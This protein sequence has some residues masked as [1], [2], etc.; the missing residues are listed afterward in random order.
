MMQS[1]PPAKKRGMIIH[2]IL[3]FVFSVAFVFSMVQLLSSDL[4]FVVSVYVLIALASGVGFALMGYRLF[5]LYNANYLLDRNFLEINWGLRFERIPVT[6]IDWIK[7]ISSFDQAIRMPLIHLPGGILGEVKDQSIGFVEYLAADTENLVLIGTAQRIFAISPEDL[8]SFMTTF[9]RI[10]ELGSLESDEG[11]SEFVNFAI[12]NAWKENDNKMLWG[13]TL[14]MNIAFLTLVIFLVP[15]YS[16]INLSVAQTNQFP[17]Q[18]PARQL[19][20]LPMINFVFSLFGI[21]LGLVF[22]RNE[23]HSTL[24]KTIWVTIPIATL[25]FGGAIYFIVTG[26]K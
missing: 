15:K 6:E 3:F 4:G 10:F 13:L 16:T 22:Y 21:L 11:R 24:A 7:H 26:G 12:V 20:L 17:E 14:F 5:G 2:G 25:F 1:F 18:V 19:M 23:K 9:N 8:E